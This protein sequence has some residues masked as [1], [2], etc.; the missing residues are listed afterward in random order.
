VNYSRL[1]EAVK[2][3]IMQIPARRSILIWAEIITCIL[4]W[5]AADILHA[6]AAVTK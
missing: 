6:I 1:I 5:K 2:E 3:L 4:A